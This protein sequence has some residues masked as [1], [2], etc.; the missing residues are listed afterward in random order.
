MAERP[1]DSAACGVDDFPRIQIKVP[2]AAKITALQALIRK[3]DGLL[4]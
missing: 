2:G 4:R 3:F 1:V